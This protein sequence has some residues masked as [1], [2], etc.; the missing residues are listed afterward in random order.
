MP[1]AFTRLERLDLFLI[2]VGGANVGEV[3]AGGLDVVVVAG[4]ARL[5]EAVELLGSEEAHGGAQVD[6]ALPLHGLKGVDGLVK[7]RPCEAP[8]AVTM[9]KRSTPSRSLSLQASKICSSGRKS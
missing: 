8:P 6:L 5:V 4:H 7:L 9:E 3:P 1:S 2:G